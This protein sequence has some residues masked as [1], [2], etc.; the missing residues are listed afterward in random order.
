VTGQLELE[1]VEAVEDEV[2]VAM[3]PVETVFANPL[4]RTTLGRLEE[5][6]LLVL[7]V[8]TFVT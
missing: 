6:P 4:V 8:D 3:V 1:A 2:S 5:M 7:D